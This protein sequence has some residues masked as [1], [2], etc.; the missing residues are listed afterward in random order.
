MFPTK[1]PSKT[2]PNHGITGKKSRAGDAFVSPNQNRKLRFNDEK[3]KRIEKRII[4]S[5]VTKLKTLFLTK[6]IEKRIENPIK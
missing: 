3:L 2:T 4:K 6:R 5:P 1:S